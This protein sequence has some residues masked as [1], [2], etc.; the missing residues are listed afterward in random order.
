MTIFARI[1]GHAWVPYALLCVFCL[2]LYL[3]GFTTI[4]PVDRDEARFAQASRQMVE[5]GDYIDIRF[6]DEPRHKKPVGIYWLQTASAKLA[7]ENGS[8][9][10]WPYRLP[11]LIGAIAAVLLTFAAGRVL[12]GSE[13]ALIGA[14]LLASCIL[15]GYEARQAKTDAVLLATVC[16]AQF[17]F[18]RAY[19]D[20]GS[21][22]PT[23]WAALGAGILIKGPI[24]PMVSGLAAA[25][26]AIADR[27]PRWLMALRPGRGA[28]LLGAMIAPWLILIALKTDGAFFQE[29]V[30]RDLL[31]KVAAGQEGHGAPPGYYLLTFPLTFWPGS[32]I[33]LLAMPWAW[34]YR[35]LAPVRFCLAWILPTW[36]IFELIPTKLAHYTLP[37]FPAIA[38]VAGAAS[39]DLVRQPRIWG[40]IVIAVWVLIGLALGIAFVG[41]SRI[42]DGRILLG[43]VFAGLAVWL[44]AI[45]LGAAAWRGRLL[46]KLP[47]GLTAATLVYATAF[48]LM[49]PNLQAIWISR[50][51]V[52]ALAAE[53]WATDAPVAIAGYA[54]PSAVFLI[55]TYT[56]LV[57]GV[58]AAAHLS[59][60]PE[61]IAV[62]AE[63][64]RAS[65]EA[66]LPDEGVAV[67]P[68][69]TV[70]G[71]N[72]AKGKWLVL[73][74]FRREES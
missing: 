59:E 60:Y 16:A 57:D 41:L 12:F 65:F 44:T 43:G 4:P 51:I 20:K 15:L 10:I 37:L 13:P 35:D 18:A 66:A 31:A 39:L 50:S 49:F 7:G 2:V 72:Y 9:P 19:M 58:G 6:Q 38:L 28:L 24:A 3:P 45:L 74:L 36:I 34:R 32:L 48:G 30:G 11:S 5:T 69:A 52:Q 21:S 71:F 54:E 46:S 22:W 1:A 68:V 27:K 29:S 63:S 62:V 67:R 33:A 53:K 14:A 73:T 42:T 64:E 70:R 40:K 55:G 23:F 8:N 47:T 25:G 17:A 56:Q 26:L 61:A